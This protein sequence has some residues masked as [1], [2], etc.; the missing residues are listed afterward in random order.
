MTRMTCM[1]PDSAD[2]GTIAQ[3][4]CADNLAAEGDIGTKHTT[5]KLPALSLAQLENI[6]CMCAQR[7]YN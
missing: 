5:P 1:L 7:Q 4:Y 6:A 3:I 2:H